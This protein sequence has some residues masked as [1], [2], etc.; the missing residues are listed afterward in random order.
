MEERNV[1]DAH[2]LCNNAFDGVHEKYVEKNSKNVFRTGPKR[3][4]ASKFDM[5]DNSAKSAILNTFYILK[6]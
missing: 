6:S 2:A 5:S 1:V 3:N 4:N